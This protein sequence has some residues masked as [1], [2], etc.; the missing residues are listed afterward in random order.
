LGK[1]RGDKAGRALSS[2][3]TST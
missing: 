1:C 2:P 3:L